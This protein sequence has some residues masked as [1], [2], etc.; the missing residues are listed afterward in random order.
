MRDTSQSH[1]VR[2][3]TQHQP[4]LFRKVHGRVLCASDAVRQMIES[5]LP[6]LRQR[7]EAAGVNVQQFNVSTDP[8]SGGNQNAYR[9]AMLE[10]FAPRTAA[11]GTPAAPRARIG[12]VDAG[13]LDVTV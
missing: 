8:G 2:C 7:L 12:R 5:Q 6:E 1:D 11:T 10:E 13:S 4:L 3:Y 9:A